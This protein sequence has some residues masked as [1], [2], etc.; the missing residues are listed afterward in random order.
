MK[1]WLVGSDTVL[2]AIYAAFAEGWIDAAGSDVARRDLAEEALFLGRLVTELLPREPEALGLLALMLY[3]EA[4]RPARRNAKGEY[5]PL[6][7]QDPALWDSQM[8]LEAETFSAA[9]AKSHPSVAISWKLRCSP[10]MS[11]AV[12][13]VTPTGKKWCNS[14]TCCWDSLARR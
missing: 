2:D 12:A 4:R 8:I 11:I 3:A 5:V 10:R 13:P 14:T 9:R 6:A 1:S 7:D